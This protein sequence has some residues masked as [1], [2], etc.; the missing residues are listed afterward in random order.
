MLLQ[1][2][3]FKA[4]RLPSEIL[5]HSL[6]CYIFR[7]LKSE[8]IQDVPD[9]L[10]IKPKQKVLPG[11]DRGPH[12][13]PASGAP[14]D[15]KE[16]VSMDVCDETTAHHQGGVIRSHGG[17]LSGSADRGHHLEDSAVTP[18]PLQHKPA[19]LIPLEESI[20]LLQSQQQLQE[21]VPKYIF[22]K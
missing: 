13:Q 6:L 16:R 19:Q 14:K 12:S 18:L 1:T 21:V 7:S 10:L 11:V 5:Y 8:S 17:R 3:P 22:N 20:N 4:K 9:Y 2:N 15:S